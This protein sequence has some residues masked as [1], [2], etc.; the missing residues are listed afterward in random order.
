MHVQCVLCDKVDELDDHSLQAKTLRNRR[1]KMY[2]CQT[3]YER[4]GKKTKE[5]HASGNFRLYRS[6]KKKDHFL[7]GD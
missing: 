6:K 1:L 3:C 7:N 5:R 4:I 2:L